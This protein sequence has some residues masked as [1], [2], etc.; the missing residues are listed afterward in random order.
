MHIDF[1]KNG[2]KGIFIN[3]SMDYGTP[4]YFPMSF[5]LLKPRASLIRILTFQCTF[6]EKNTRILARLTLRLEPLQN[7][8]RQ[9]DMAATWSIVACA[10]RIMS[11]AKAKWDHFGS[12]DNNLIGFHYLSPITLVIIW[13]NLSIQR[14]NRGG[15]IWS[16]C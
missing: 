9:E 12:L 4:R 13:D 11:S 15:E 7:K 14:T 1:N 5:V 3:S 10:N 2:L 16:P 6:F 8:S